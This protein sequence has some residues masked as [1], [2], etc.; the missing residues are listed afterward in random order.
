MTRRQVQENEGRLTEKLTE[1][2]KQNRIA[3]ARE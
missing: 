1:V 2:G 3:S